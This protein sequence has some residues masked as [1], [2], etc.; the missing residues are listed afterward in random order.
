VLPKNAWLTSLVAQSP[1]VASASAAVATPATGAAAATQVPTA[2]VIGGYALSH[3]VVAETL[4]RLALVPQ[5]ANVSLQQTQRAQVLN[6]NA[7][8]FGIAADVR[9]PGGHG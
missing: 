2:F 9:A 6:R 5:L 8:Q 7:I 1:G 4:Q 3:A